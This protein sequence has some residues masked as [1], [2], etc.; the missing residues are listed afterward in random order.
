MIN[1]FSAFQPGEPTPPTLPNSFSDRAIRVLCADDVPTVLTS[2]K[3]LIDKF[4]TKR[5]CTAGLHGKW[6]ASFKCNFR[7]SLPATRF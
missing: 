3:C 7:F 1:P 4:S 6:K 2:M 5:E